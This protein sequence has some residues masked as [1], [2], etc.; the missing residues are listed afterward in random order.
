MGLITD[1]RSIQ[2]RAKI[3]AL[4]LNKYLSNIVISEEIGSDKPNL[5]NY[6]IFEEKYAEKKFKFL[7]I[8]DNL[9][10]DFVTPNKLGWYTICLMDKDGLNVHSQ[11]V[12][13][14]NKFLPKIK[15]NSIIELK[16]III[17][18]DN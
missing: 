11:N 13:V 18:L 8:G 1:G 15:I 16:D 7:Y 14:A 17:N 12:L 9:K 2:Q 6:Q 3:K 5:K 10:K 4:G